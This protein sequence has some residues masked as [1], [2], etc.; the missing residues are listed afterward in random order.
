MLLSI[1]DLEKITV[2]DIMVPRNEIVGIDISK[3]WDVILQ[4]LGT[5]QHTRLPVFDGGIDELKGI[6]H[7]RRVLGLYVENRLTRDSLLALAREPYYVPAGTPLNQQLV[8]FQHHKRRIG[9][10]VDEY[11]DLLGLVTFE[12]ILEEI[13]GDFTS[14][15]A[16][17]MRQITRQP[18]DSVLVAGA[19]TI[20]N[21][22]RATG[23]KLQTSG[24]R[25]LNGLILEYLEDMPQPGTSIKIGDYTVE[26]TEVQD[27]VVKMVRIRPPATAGT[28]KAP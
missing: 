9:F 1:I 23:W 7:M 26:I 19:T 15:P 10:V 12:D 24:P 6:V 13:V 21:F 8:N 27:K 2:E 17:R 22:N 11:G 16:L 20:R 28:V 14:D 4:N 3:D 18:D 25:T 5:N